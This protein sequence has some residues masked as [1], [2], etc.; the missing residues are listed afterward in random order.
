M[1][2]SLPF[3]GTPQT[4]GRL[5][6]FLVPDIGFG[7]WRFG[8][9]SADEAGNLSLVSNVVALTVLDSIPPS[10]I[11][12]LRATEST[13]TSVTLEWTA[14]GGDGGTGRASEY[15]IR[16]ATEEITAANWEQATAFG[17]PPTPAAVGATEQLVVD[18]LLSSTLYFF[19]VRARDAQENE[20]PLSNSVSKATL[21]P[22]VVR[23]TSSPGSLGAFFPHWSPDGTQI[24][25]NADWDRQFYDQVYVVSS[26]AP[27][28]PLRISNV[29]EGALRPEWSPDG[30]SLAFIGNRAVDPNTVRELWTMDPSPFSVPFRVASHNPDIIQFSAWSPDGQTLAYSVSTPF[31][32]PPGPTRV[33][34]VP[35]GGGAPTL[36]V[37]PDGAVNGMDWSQDGSSIAIGT[38]RDGNYNVWLFPLAGGEPTR[39]TEHPADD[40]RP[41]WSPD[42]KRIAFGSD[43]AG[44]FDIWIVSA[45]GGEPTRVTV[46]AG[47]ELD[48]SWSPDGKRLAYGAQ[49]DGISD[50]WIQDIE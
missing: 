16:Y 4:A 6:Q 3:P 8:L 12:D 44:T 46:G 19:G 15:L 10:Q 23:V 25:F 11:T 32:L 26:T 28:T 38:D 41:S 30:G 35:V 49:E 17:S 18:G 42:G 1:A 43:R 27:F 34:T 7:E 40:L 33:Y 45:S 24:A 5:E 48:S 50:I 14:P 21:S 20:A 36:F 13:R 29:T 39:L 22:S 31:G 2:I 47:N 37:E 9:K